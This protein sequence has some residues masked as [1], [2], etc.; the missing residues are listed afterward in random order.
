M[1]TS[2]HLCPLTFTPSS[3]SLDVRSLLLLVIEQQ[4]AQP[5]TPHSSAAVGSCK[6]TSSVLTEEGAMFRVV[7]CGGKHRTSD[8]ACESL[9]L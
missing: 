3:L 8:G 6:S 5:L 2:N 7:I 1:S 4:P 9:K